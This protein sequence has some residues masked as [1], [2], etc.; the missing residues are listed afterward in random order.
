[1]P[2]RRFDYTL[3]VSPKF[4]SAEGW[5]R[6]KQRLRNALTGW[7]V[8][9]LIA[10]PQI[11]TQPNIKFMTRSGMETRPYKIHKYFV[12]SNL[13]R[14]GGVTPYKTHKNPKGAMIS[15]INRPH[16]H[17]LHPRPRSRS[18]PHSPRSHPRRRQYR[19]AFQVPSDR[20]KTNPCT[21]VRSSSKKSPIRE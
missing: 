5:Q 16:Y 6:R 13:R 19:R 17:H 9:A 20:P 15:Q 7:S 18:H 8:G 14:A 11:K 12:K 1:M 4:P 10:R 21:S 3:D 2:S